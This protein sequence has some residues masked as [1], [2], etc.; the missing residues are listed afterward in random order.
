MPHVPAWQQ[1]ANRRGFEEEGEDPFFNQGA[2]GADIHLAPSGPAALQPHKIDF[3]DPAAAA[4]PAP[5]ASAPVAPS[6][7]QP[8]KQEI[9]KEEVV[10]QKQ[11]PSTSVKISYAPPQSSSHFEIEDAD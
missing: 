5:P 11:P 6:A 10:V 7:P 9:I 2:A 8:V 1:E 3:E 4:A